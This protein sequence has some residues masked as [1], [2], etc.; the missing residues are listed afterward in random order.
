MNIPEK[1]VTEKKQT[2]QCS[3]STASE[4]STVHLV[5]KDHMGL[6][7]FSRTLL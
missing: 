5:S 4:L 1:N 6:Y 2:L 3:P 7:Q